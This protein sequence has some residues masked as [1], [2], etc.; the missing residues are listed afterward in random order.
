MVRRL[1]LALAL[2]VAVPA[3]AKKPHPKPAPETAPAAAPA[4]TAATDEGSEATEEGSEATDDDADTTDTGQE[5]T[6]ETVPPLHV[7]PDEM[8]TLLQTD[9]KDLIELK[10]AYEDFCSGELGQ[11]E[12]DNLQLLTQEKPAE[13]ADLQ[14]KA[15]AII[16]KRQGTNPSAAA[17][18]LA[19]A[20]LAD[21]DLAYSMRPTERMNDKQKAKF[22][23]ILE[24]E[25]WPSFKGVDA[26]AKAYLVAIEKGASD[27]SPWKKRA[28]DLIASMEAAGRGERP[29]EPAPAPEGQAPADGQAPA[30][31]APADGDGDGD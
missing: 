14:D 17:F 24:N 13:L 29:P 4:P 10:K 5:I 15:V 31:Q 18:L 23:G 20:M 1:T 16:K 8:D 6:H 12:N 9:S 27:K 21:A 30:A 22:W 25:I 28:A 26:D 2:L 19:N 7:P 11:N 3:L